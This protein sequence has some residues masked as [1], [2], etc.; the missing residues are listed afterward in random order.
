MLL[1]K[2]END[3]GALQSSRRLSR[4][5]RS[6]D[7]DISD[8]ARPNSTIRVRS[9]LTCQGKGLDEGRIRKEIPTKSGS[10]AE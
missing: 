7:L 5:Q 4:T 10:N 2:P 3:L 9:C 6:L 1:Y 8:M